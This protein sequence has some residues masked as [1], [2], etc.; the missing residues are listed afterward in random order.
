M[1]CKATHGLLR[2][3]NR[4]GTALP[5]RL[6]LR[7]CP[8]ALEKCSQGMNILVIT[9]TNGK[10]TSARIAEKALYLAGKDVI[11]NRSGANLVDGITCELILNTN[12]F[13][14]PKAKWAV[15]ECDEASCRRVIAAIKP[16]A[17]LVTNLFRD[18]LDRYGSVKAPRD[19][20]AEGLSA[21]PDTVLCYNADSPL[22]ASISELVPNKALGFGFECGR[23]KSIGSNEDKSCPICGSTMSF[24]KIS[25]ANLGNFCCHRCGFK[26]DT[27]LLSVSD[28]LSDGSFVVEGNGRR[29]LVK[30]ALPGMYNIYNAVGVASLCKA[31]GIDTA[32]AFMAA[33]DFE[34]GFGRMES[35]DLGKKGAQMILIKNAA[36][37]DQTLKYISGLK[38][39]KTIVLAINNRPSDGT[40]ISWLYDADFASLSRMR[41]LKRVIVCGDRASETADVLKSKSITCEYAG[42]YDILLKILSKEGNYIFLLP[43]Y[44]AMLELRQKL[45]KALGGKNFWE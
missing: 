41:G 11:L 35:F 29:E 39:N 38:D 32:L 37:A 5:G 8:E 43:T 20:I 44:T 21:S 16:K 45:V 40:D 4:G 19:A 22:S 27:P 1:V 26:R 2:L 23:G 33:E 3:L 7:L 36:A 6:A 24:D 25:Y 10:T 14:K 18:Q 13:L 30:A 34:C 15:I 28:I 17:V 9:G 12:M 31:V 42:D